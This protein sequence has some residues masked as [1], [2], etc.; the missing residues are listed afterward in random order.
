[1]FDLFA[2]SI[3]SLLGA[4][5]PGPA[6]FIIIKNSLSY[7]R[8][9]GFLT[10]LG[11]S[12][13]LIIHLTYC[14][15]GLDFVLSRGS[16]PYTFIKVL[17]A[18]Y[19]FYL[20]FRAIRSSFKKRLEITCPIQQDSL[21][22][23]GAVKQGFLANLL[24]PENA[25]YFLAIFSQFIVEDTPAM[26]RVEYALINW[27]TALIWYSTLAYLVTMRVFLN[28]IHHFKIYTERAMGMIFI[29]LSIRLL[30]V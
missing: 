19:L 21:S 15:I 18:C 11:I 24:N 14:M 8:R 5:A 29:L 3:V 1:M 22:K 9:I 20:G 26:V 30:F 13:A 16:T 10:A 28:K 4:M 27:S 25:L 12:F 7:S 2:V 23:T 6:F 17:G